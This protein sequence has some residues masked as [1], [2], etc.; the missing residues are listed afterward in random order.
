[1]DDVAKIA[2]GLTGAMREGLLRK[3]C[4]SWA[5]DTPACM[6][7]REQTGFALKR[8]GLCVATGTAA[9][10]LTPLGRSVRGYLE[11]GDG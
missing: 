10:L 1:M 4:R 11:N 8:R 9:W 5:G 7:P 6:P 3:P 2:R